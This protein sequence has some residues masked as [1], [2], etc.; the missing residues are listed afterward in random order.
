MKEAIIKYKDAKTQELLKGLARY[1]NF[2]I[3]FSKE[4]KTPKRKYD[5]INKVPVIRGDRSIDV[6]A[7]NKIFTG[8]NL[9]A[10]KIRTEGWQ[11]VK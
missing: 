6:T 11:R 9:D 5:Y 8:K 1:F 4:P 7:L 2:S 10:K 3:S